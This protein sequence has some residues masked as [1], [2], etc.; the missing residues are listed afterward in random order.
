MKNEIFDIDWIDF[1]REPQCDPDPHFPNGKDI[2]LYES[3]RKEYN[4]NRTC[5]VSLPYP[6]KRCG[7]YQIYCTLCGS[8]IYVTTAGRKDDPKSIEIPCSLDM[9][10]H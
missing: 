2:R 3:E 7:V 5:I 6:A 1:E 8:K 10:S 9:I 4:I